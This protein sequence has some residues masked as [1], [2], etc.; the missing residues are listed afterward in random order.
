MMNKVTRQYNKLPIP[1]ALETVI[2]GDTMKAETR[3]IHRLLC[4][5]IKIVLSVAG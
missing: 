1:E 5:T 3:R 4:G 2:K